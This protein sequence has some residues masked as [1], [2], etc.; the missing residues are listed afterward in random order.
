MTQASPSA[1]AHTLHHI[2]LAEGSEESFA[3]A[4]LAWIDVERNTIHLICAGHPAPVLL[5][6]GVAPLKVKPFLPLGV[7]GDNVTW[8]PTSM[9]LP[10]AWTL[11]FYTD[12]LVEMRDRSGA[13][14]RFGLDGLSSRL[15]PLAGHVITSADLADLVHG[16]VATSGEA[17]SDDVAALAVSTRRLA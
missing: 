14:G 17:P 16:V 8:Q 13:E 7:A 3:T 11:F 2:V 9:E 10:P 15:R 6:E 4:V 5:S 12:G 1:I